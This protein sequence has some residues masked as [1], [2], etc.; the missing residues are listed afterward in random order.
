MATTTATAI[1]VPATRQQHGGQLLWCVEQ[2]G[3]SQLI[4][5]PNLCRELNSPPAQFEL[6]LFR[7]GLVW[8][9]L[10]SPA[11]LT[12]LLVYIYIYIYTLQ[13]KLFVLFV[14]T[15]NYHDNCSLEC[16]GRL[17]RTNLDLFQLFVF[18]FRSLVCF[19]ATFLTLFKLVALVF[20]FVLQLVCLS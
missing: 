8:F 20:V 1:V 14:A 11:K 10:L 18:F 12:E 5:G 9:G 17:M 13:G 16:K 6:A 4:Y 3:F 15:N 7:F 19:F 2:F